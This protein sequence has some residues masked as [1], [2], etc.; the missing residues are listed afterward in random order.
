MRIDSSGNVG[1][2]TSSPESKLYVK[3]SDTNSNVASFSNTDTLNGN[4]VYIKAGGI[5]AGKYALYIE[6]GSGTAI[7]NL[8]ASGNLGI[9]TNTPAYKLEVSGTAAATDFNSLSDARFKHNIKK[10][11]NALDKV[12]TISGYTFV[13]NETDEE[14]CG[15]LAQEIEEVLPEAVREHND[16]KT[17][18]YGGIVGLLIEAIKEQG[19]QIQ[20]LKDMLNQP[21]S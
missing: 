16:R 3:T 12:N 19:R 13:L 8:L 5:N 4:G 18:S 9:G 10:I 15:V 2:G 7:L 14:S 11:D 21:S 17:V 1:I 20:E 6:D